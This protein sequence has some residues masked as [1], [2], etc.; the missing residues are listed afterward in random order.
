MQ[1][2]LL[3][4]RNGHEIAFAEVRHGTQDM[5]LQPA[6]LAPR[7]SGAFILDTPLGCN[8]NVTPEPAVDQYSGVVVVLP[9]GK[10]HVRI[11][12]VTLSVPCGLGESQLGWAKG[13]VFN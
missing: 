6:I 4:I 10:G 1:P 5:S 8:A 3:G 2:K 7:M 11:V 12:G 13:F 9:G